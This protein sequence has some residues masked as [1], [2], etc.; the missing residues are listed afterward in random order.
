MK[1]ADRVTGKA[2]RLLQIERVLLA[3]PEGLTQ[4][5]LARRCGVHRS[6]IFRNLRDLEEA[7]VPLWEDD[8]GRIGINREAYLTHI[9][10]TLHESMAVFLAAR[11]LAR[12]SDKPNPHAVEALLKLGV[13]LESLAPQIGRHI[14]RTS[15]ALRIRPLPER[16]D[17]LHT[18]E[19]LT[20][21][22]SIG[23]KVRLL[24][25]P[26]RARRAFEHTFAPYFLEP[27]AIGYGTY[28]IGLAEPPGV[29]RTRK[30]ERIEGITLTDEPFDIP[31][32]F[33]PVNLL[34]GAWGIWFD[35][36]DR[37]TKI[38]L[39]FH[40]RVARRVRESVW[41]P[42]QRIEEDS[43]GHLLWTA[44]VD[45]IQELLP[46]VRGWG[47]DCEVLE[48]GELKQQMIGEARRL[49]R[50]Y[51][52]DVKPSESQPLPARATARERLKASL[53]SNEESDHVG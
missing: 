3:H 9:R 6:T 51:G 38:V 19:T 34:A 46:W 10:L 25:R 35:E 13:A 49:A 2:A 29:L 30:V 14:V 31:Q 45:E 18:L 1:D 20:Q 22:W 21:A 27:S 17:Y 37:P 16:R 44:E 53:L 23:R 24:Y 39:R 15:E 36:E 7:G 41:H 28:A 47:A 43:D 4:A 5:E 50:L 33:D 42:S 11:L 40:R 26:L 48:P 12:Y 52:L 32:D 8:N